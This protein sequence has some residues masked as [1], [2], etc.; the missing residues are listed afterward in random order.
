MPRLIAKHGITLERYNASLQNK[1]A[2]IESYK[3]CYL[4]L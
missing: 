1:N 3:L 4:M 2:D